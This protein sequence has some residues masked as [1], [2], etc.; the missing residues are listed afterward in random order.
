[1]LRSKYTYTMPFALPLNVGINV[2]VTMTWRPGQLSNKGTS[3][4]AQCSAVYRFPTAF[5]TIEKNA[6]IML[7]IMIVK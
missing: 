2:L 5:I 7:A 4:L 1:M 3:D 6:I